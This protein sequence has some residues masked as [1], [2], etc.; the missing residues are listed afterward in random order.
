L[1]KYG[2]VNAQQLRDV[3]MTFPE[4]KKPRIR[5]IS[6]Q[7]RREKR[8]KQFWDRARITV[9]RQEAKRQRLEDAT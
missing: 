4:E 6:Q 9:A 8:D 5:G 1:R 7:H 3:K 2:C